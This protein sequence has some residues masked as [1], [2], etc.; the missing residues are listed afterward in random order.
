MTRDI[1]QGR[2]AGFLRQLTTP[3]TVKPLM[4]PLNVA[5]EYAGKNRS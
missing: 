1:K 3:T 5:L 2:E 4:D